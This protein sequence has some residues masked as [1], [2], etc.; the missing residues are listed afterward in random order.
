MAALTITAANVI[1]V[2]GYSF[3]T[4]L[5]AAAITIGQSLYVDSSDQWALAD[6]DALATGVAVAISLSQAAAAG[7][8]VIGITGGDLGLG[9]ILTV[10]IPYCVGLA[11]GSIGPYSDLASG[12]F[13]CLVGWPT[14]TANLRLAF[15]AST[16][17][18]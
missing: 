17:A 12:D 11:G 3:K 14:T 4:R 15:V 13:P 1:P 10:G 7:Q 2:S 6:A 9:A 18:I 16:V 5:S 8:P